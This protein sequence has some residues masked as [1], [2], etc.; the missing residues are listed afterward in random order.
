[1]FSTKLVILRELYFAGLRP[2]V[3]WPRNELKN[4]NINAF[5]V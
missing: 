2:R 4:A 5:E 1:M 3:G